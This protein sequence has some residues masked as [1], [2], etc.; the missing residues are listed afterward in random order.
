MEIDS[1]PGN[2]HGI[3]RRAHAILTDDF[4]DRDGHP[5]RE[6]LDRVLALLRERLHSKDQ[7]G[8]AGPV[9]TAKALPEHRDGGR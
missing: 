6:A 9:R 3:P 7:S 8:Q 2:L 1:S 5:T 4:V